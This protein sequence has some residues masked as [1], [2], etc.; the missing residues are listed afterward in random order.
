MDVV[1][2]ISNERGTYAMF[3]CVDHG[4]LEIESEGS[5]LGVAY[6][7]DCS[8]R[9]ERRAQSLPPGVHGRSMGPTE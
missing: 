5:V 1:R 8:R 9:V 4:Q 2:S 3:L 6:E 7:G